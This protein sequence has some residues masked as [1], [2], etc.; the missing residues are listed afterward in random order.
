MVRKFGRISS[1]NNNNN[2]CQPSSEARFCPPANK[3]EEGHMK[4][5]VLD[6]GRTC[7]FALVTARASEFILLFPAARVSRT[8]K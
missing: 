8:R 4:K 7:P 1:N 6:Q 5:V 2:N 3:Q